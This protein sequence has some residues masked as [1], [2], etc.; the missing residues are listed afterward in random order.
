MKV[1]TDARSMAGVVVL[2]ATLILPMTSRA[3]GQE[4]FQF[5]PGQT[6]FIHAETV[7]GLNDSV[8][9]QKLH[10][11]FLKRKVFKVTNKLE[12]ADFVFLVY[13]EY[14]MHKLKDYSNQDSK[15]WKSDWKEKRVLMFAEGFA[16]TRNAYEKGFSSREALR[17]AAR[18][19]WLAGGER[20]A[21]GHERRSSVLVKTFHSQYMDVP[22]SPRAGSSVPGSFALGSGQSVYIVA[23][24]MTG[25]DDIRLEGNLI[26][27]FSRKKKFRIAGNLSEADFVFLVYS[28][29]RSV[30]RTNILKIW[31]PGPTENALVYAEA[32]AITPDQFGK[33]VHDLKMLREVAYWQRTIGSGQVGALSLF[34]LPPKRRYRG[35]VKQFHNDVVH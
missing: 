17:L 6:V 20:S 30:T 31:D 25:P 26:K 15:W 2:G 18:W 16:V 34:G 28:Q 27:E 23:H 21:S 33:Y 8:L 35:L 14:R 11:K 4:E 7:A 19:Q 32:Y 22:A 29:N 5:S 12:L 24:K 13:S 10:K 1:S 3:G 9:E